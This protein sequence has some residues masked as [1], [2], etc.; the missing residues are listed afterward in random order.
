MSGA[1]P[2]PVNENYILFV[3]GQCPDCREFMA[4]LQEN[5]DKLKLSIQLINVDTQQYPS[6]VQMV[7]AI[8]VQV[9]NAT[10]SFLQGG[11]AF[12]WLKEKVMN[13]N[14]SGISPDQHNFSFLEQQQN[15]T[16]LDSKRTSTFNDAA[17]CPTSALPNS[18]S[19]TQPKQLPPQLQ[20]QVIKKAD[21]NFAN[22]AAL[23]N[24][25]NIEA[26]RQAEL[27]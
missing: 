5:Q 11:Q 13:A 27:Q 4:I 6:Q 23:N 17:Q 24:L 16:I 2:P 3:S 8:V 7:P 1:P 10:T 15:Q 12:Q 19:Q 22:Q 20:P 14:I 26:R 18:Q 21:E 9:N 25:A